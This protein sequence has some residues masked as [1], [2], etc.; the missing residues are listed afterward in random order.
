[1]KLFPQS[2]LFILIVSMCAVNSIQ[3]QFFLNGTAITLNDSCYQL[4][5]TNNWEVGSI[6]NGDLVNLEESFDVI[7][8]VFLG[9]QDETGA[10]GIVFA[11]QPISTSIGVGGGDIGIGGVTPSLGVEI[12]TYLNENFADPIADHLTV[13][14]DGNLNHNTPEV[15]L[16]GPIQA[17]SITD[18]IEDCS[19]HA[20]RVTWDAQAQTLSVYFDCELRL[21]YTSDIVETIF[22]GDPLVYW[23][24]TS[25]TGGL[26]NVHEICFSYTS[27]ID[28]LAD[29]TTCPGEAVQLEASGG[30]SYNWSPA[31]GLSAT[32][33][34]NPMAA[35]TETT[36]Y[37]VEIFDDCGVPFYDDVLVIIDN[38][39]FDLSL[40]TD[41]ADLETVFPGQTFSL[42]AVVEA[43][44]LND[45]T[46]SWSTTGSSS[47]VSPDMVMTNVVANSMEGTES[48]S[49]QVSS[50]AGC[51]Q[52][53]V[54]TI[55]I[56]TPLFEMPNVFSPNGD[57]VNDRFGLFTLAQ[58]DSYNCK[59]FNRWG[60]VVFETTSSTQ[61]FW[62]GTYN[63]NVAPADVYIYQANFE[64]GGVQ[65]ER[66]GNITLVR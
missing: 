58:L 55:E 59:V 23:G 61:P 8:D 18:N 32:D 17:S 35:P 5:S 4:T 39:Q 52:D 47:L 28:E 44:S 2:L 40:T 66:E 42:T 62:D 27:F 38:E 63:N 22:G 46:Y 31:E 20:F 15:T 37:T 45:Y 64:I 24:F 25:A 7:V 1:M 65:Y 10:D 49:L 53:T 16:A 21:T 50:P 43:D 60:Q 57:N 26:N 12:D 29:Q 13:V 56:T 3:A 51:T 11:L 19:Y 33:I 14:R 6:W 34:A 9:C 41:P 54:I 30:S 48:I 36:L